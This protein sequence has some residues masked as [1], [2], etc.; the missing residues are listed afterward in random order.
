[1][2]KLIEFRDIFGQFCCLGG[3]VLLAALFGDLGQFGLVK[4]SALGEGELVACLGL[5]RRRLRS[6]IAT[7]IEGLGLSLHCVGRI[8]GVDLLNV[9]GFWNQK[10]RASA[11]LVEV[12]VDKCAGIGLLKSNQH[13]LDRS[14]RGLGLGCD[15]TRGIA[16]CDHD[17]L[18]CW[19]L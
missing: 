16:C 13:L 7:V 9:V 1:M 15:G 3:F 8:L 11:Y 12:A 10:D 2:G 5:G 4:R 6:C 17:G 19:F 18:G 14:V